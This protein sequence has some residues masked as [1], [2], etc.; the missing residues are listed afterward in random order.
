MESVDPEGNPTLLNTARPKRVAS[1]RRC[2]STKCSRSSVRRATAIPCMARFSLISL[3]VCMLEREGSLRQ[4]TQVTTR[5]HVCAR[6]PPRPKRS[7]LEDHK[8]QG[9]AHSRNTPKRI[10]SLET[11]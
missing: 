2:S 8:T 11:F 1:T 10:R 4:V 7:D 9:E 6:L 3:G 5:E